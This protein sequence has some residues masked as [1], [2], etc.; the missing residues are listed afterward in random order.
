MLHA[1]DALTLS[2]R[3][4]WETSGNKHPEPTA[5]AG[6][7][8]A[9][10]NSHVLAVA[11]PSLSLPA[12]AAPLAMS[13]RR[14]C[15]WQLPVAVAR[16]QLQLATTGTAQHDGTAGTAVGTAGTAGTAGNAQ[17]DAAAYV[18]A[19]TSDERGVVTAAATAVHAMLFGFPV[20]CLEQAFQEHWEHAT[21]TF[22]ALAFLLV[23]LMSWKALVHLA[24][25]AESMVDEAAAR[26]SETDGQ[27]LLATIGA[28]L[29]IA[30][31]LLTVHRRVRRGFLHICSVGFCFAFSLLVGVGVSAISMV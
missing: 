24:R 6:D 15:R 21:R 8:A 20:P 30:G 9:A 3:P 29:Y 17:H 12:S 5:A 25:A 16:T 18:V 13:V 1:S 28:P 22:D 7:P 4:I 19:A 11:S 2:L 23:L 14:R 26:Q 31:Y 27:I 10:E